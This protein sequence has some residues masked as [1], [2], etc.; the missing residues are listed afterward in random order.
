MAA[1]ALLTDYVLTVAVSVAAGVAA[2]T[3]IF[4]GL[5]D[6]R[7]LVGVGFIALLWIGNLRGLQETRTSSRP[8]LHLPRRH[9]RPAR[10]RRL[11][12]GLRLAAPL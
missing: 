9:L 6:Q 11:A 12:G 4:P 10:L 3:S 8:H 1:G 5:H 2:L 7:V